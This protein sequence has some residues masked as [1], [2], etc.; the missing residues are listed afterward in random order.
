[1]E[2]KAALRVILD[3]VWKPEGGPLRVTVSFVQIATVYSAAPSS[4]LGTAIWYS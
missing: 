1:M 3:H 4:D 2:T